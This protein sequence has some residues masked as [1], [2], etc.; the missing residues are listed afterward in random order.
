MVRSRKFVSPFPFASMRL[1]GRMLINDVSSRMDVQAVNA[2]RTWIIDQ[3]A[4]LIRNGAI[5]K[6]DDW[7]QSI[8]DWFVLHGIFVL[9][10]KS[11]KSPIKAVRHR[12]ASMLVSF[13]EHLYFDLGPR[14]TE[15]QILRRPAQSLSR[16]GAQLSCRVD[17]AVGLHQRQANR[18]I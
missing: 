13:I 14:N 17:I 15:A 9:E 2:R 16:T 11:A 5:P 4:A 12:Y 8:L 6:S 18:S 1:I 7:I 10:K 3:L